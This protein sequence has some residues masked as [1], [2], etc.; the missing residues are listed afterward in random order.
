M[1][2]RETGGSVR[3]WVTHLEEQQRQR[4]STVNSKIMATTI[5]LSPVMH[6]A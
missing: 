6:S 5:P 1:S 3:G 2:V 4:K